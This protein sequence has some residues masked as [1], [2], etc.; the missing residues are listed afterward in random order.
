MGRGGCIIGK[1][2]RSWKSI[3]KSNNMLILLSSGSPSIPRGG[4]GSVSGVTAY[5]EIARRVVGRVGDGV[6]EIDA[7]SVAK[8]RVLHGGVLLGQKVLHE[9]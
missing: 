5:A 9:G 3:W 2:K 1:T 8:P 7:R 6:D 4:W